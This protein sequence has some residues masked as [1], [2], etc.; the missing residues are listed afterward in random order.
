MDDSGTDNED[1]DDKRGMNYCLDGYLDHDLN[2]P[3]KNTKG[4]HFK[5]NGKS[6]LC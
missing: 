5:R 6:I 1:S 4:G 2:D 3:R